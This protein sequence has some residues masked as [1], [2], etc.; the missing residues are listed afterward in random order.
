MP[1]IPTDA[2]N[3]KQRSGPP[4]GAPIASPQMQPG[5]VAPEESAG[6]PQ[7]G[8]PGYDEYQEFLAY[9]A[10]K[11]KGPA[12]AEKAADPAD[13]EAPANTPVPA[14]ELIGLVN[15][16]ANSNPLIASQIALL[17]S[18]APS[19]DL[20]RAIGKA[21]EYED[22]ALIDVAYIKEAGGANAAHVET[23]A[24]SLVQTCLAAAE[25]AVQGVYRAA[26][27]E[28]QWNAAAAAFNKSAPEHL[29]AVVGPLVKSGDPKKIA[30]GVKFVLEFAQKEGHVATPAELV[31]G[32][33]GAPASSQALSKAEFQ[34]E[35]RKLDP[36][37]RTFIQDRQ[38]L[39]R[40]RSL[41][42][43]LGR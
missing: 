31:Q 24:K 37:S 33:Q 4:S 15:E 42:K 29:K 7:V 41:G 13:A 32:G 3:V 25:E 18:T 36:Q 6:V 30:A 40:R 39:F 26:G 20:N 38:E 27:G 34:T 10:E 17:T 19:I 11:A 14:E 8:D 43:Q 16:A 21:L 5:F 35:L 12:P 28:A 22:L 2:E 1:P 23:V 9:K